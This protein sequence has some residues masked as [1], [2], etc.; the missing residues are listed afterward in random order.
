MN[1]AA[2]SFLRNY[3]KAHDC[4]QSGKLHLALGYL[5]RTVSENPAFF[6]AYHLLG[7]VFRKLGRTEEAASIM[8][9][10][11]RTL[12]FDPEVKLEMARLECD[13]GRL[14]HA[15]KILQGLLNRRPENSEAHCLIGEIYRS[16]G[17]YDKAERFYARCLE[18]EPSHWGARRGI[19]EMLR[20]PL[21]VQNGKAAASS[22]LEPALAS[23]A[24]SPERRLA[25]AVEQIRQGQIDTAVASLRELEREYPN[26]EMIALTLAEAFQKR[27]DRDDAINHLEEFLAFRQHSPLVHLQCAPLYNAARDFTRARQ[28]LEKALELDPDFYEARY[29]LGVTC[30]LQGDLEGAVS[31]YRSAMEM[32]PEDVRLYVNLAHIAVKKEEYGQAESDLRS[33]LKIDPN[34]EDAWFL[35]GHIYYRQSRFR[36][37]GQCYQALVGLSPENKEAIKWLARSCHQLKDYQGARKHWERTLE[38]DPTDS[39]AIQ[40]LSKL[41]DF[42][43]R[44]KA[45]KQDRPS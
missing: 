8:E 26:H 27:G 19:N 1:E 38:L 31:A 10:L 3:Q 34:Y 12:G 11:D 13:R 22:P 30:Q 25:G 5:Q 16:E 45:I 36:E 14:K 40:Q 33:G 42:L 17:K 20:H 44:R 37:A 18:I 15:R 28:H 41:R 9:K 39:S 43:S 35:L 21:E 32:M 2:H 4:L 7:E 24:S 29:E 6:D 23:H